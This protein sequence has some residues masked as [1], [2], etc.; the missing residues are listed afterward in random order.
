M[1]PRLTP[2][3]LAVGLLIS[4]SAL[5]AQSTTEKKAEQLDTVVVTG[6]RASLQTAV[7]VKRNASAVVD[8]V[9]AEDVGKL[10]DNDVGQALGRIPGI[11]VG[12]DFGQGASVSIRGTDPQMTYTTLN[13]Q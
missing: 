5:L 13:G 8:A 11:S 9:S 3:A 10:P 6:I 4:H 7:N 2:A 1:S 12:K